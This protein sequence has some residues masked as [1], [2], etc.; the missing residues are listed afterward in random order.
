MVALGPVYL[1][2]KWRILY[3]NTCLDTNVKLNSFTS[4]SLYRYTVMLCCVS[5]VTLSPKVR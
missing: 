3:L 4:S 1:V 5:C 2:E